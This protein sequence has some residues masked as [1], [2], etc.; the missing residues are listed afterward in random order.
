[1]SELAGEIRRLYGSPISDADAQEFLEKYPLQ[2]I[3]EWGT[4]LF[5]ISGFLHAHCCSCKG[6]LFC[7]TGL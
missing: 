5:I 2:T 7:C 3:Y 1:M 6:T 4:H